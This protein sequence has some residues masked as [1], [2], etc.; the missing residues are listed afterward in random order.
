M[1]TGRS[2]STVMRAL[3][4]SILHYLGYSGERS[5]HANQH[6]YGRLILKL[7]TVPSPGLPCP[8]LVGCSPTC[9][10]KFSHPHAPNTCTASEP[11]AAIFVCSYDGFTGLHPHS[12]IIQVLYRDPD[13][14]LMNAV[15]ACNI[16][17]RRPKIQMLPTVCS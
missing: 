8:I 12:R 17:H 15:I 14:G 5:R 9:R 1:I 11:T 13:S 6:R 16:Q 3:G 10:S 2:T 7:V 4:L